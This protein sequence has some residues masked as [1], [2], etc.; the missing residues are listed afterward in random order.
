MAQQIPNDPNSTAHYL[1]VIPDQSR[2]PGFENTPS[3]QGLDAR[4]GEKKA[5]AFDLPKDVVEVGR[6]NLRA[7]RQTFE[8]PGANTY[9]RYDQSFAG[10]TSNASSSVEIDVVANIYAANQEAAGAAINPGGNL[11]LVA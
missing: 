6:E 3:E 7:R 8:R 1:A 2:R 4:V 5:R 10:N 11:N 9:S